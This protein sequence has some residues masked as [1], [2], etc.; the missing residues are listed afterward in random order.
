MRE[1]R[2]LG[3]RSYTLEN[4]SFATNVELFANAEVIVSPHGAGLT[5]IIFAEDASVIELSTLSNP[6]PAFYHLSQQLGHSYRHISCP[7][8]NEAKYEIQENMTVSPTRVI[9]AVE[10]ALD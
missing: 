7:A 3:F 4:Q 9:E 1:L 8:T 5:D 10:S 2:Q 6:S